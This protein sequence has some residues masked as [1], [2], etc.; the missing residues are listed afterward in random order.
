MITTRMGRDVTA[1]TI[2]DVPTVATGV[3]GGANQSEAINAAIAAVPNGTKARPS[4]I[5]L[6]YG[7]ADGREYQ[8]D[9]SIRLEG[10]TGV[11]FQGPSLNNK[12][13]VARRLRTTSV[14]T[15]TNG[16]STSGS[17]TYSAAGVT[18]V[19]GR[20]LTGTNIPDGT[21][22]DVGGD[23]SCTMTKA[24]T[25]TGTG[26]SG[27]QAASSTSLEAGVHEGYQHVNVK[28]CTDTI[29]RWIHAVG[30]KGPNPDPAT[31]VEEADGVSYA[32]AFGIGNG[33]GSISEAEHAFNVQGGSRVTVRDVKSTNVAGYNLN[34][35]SAG[36]G[37]D[38]NGVR[39]SAAYN[40]D[41][42]YPT[43]WGACFNTCFGIRVA[44]LTVFRGG[45]GGCDHE[46]LG[47]DWTIEGTEIWD[48]WISCR[49]VA[50][51]A[52]G[53]RS[54]DEVY[55]HDGHVKRAANSHGIVAC[56]DLRGG[57]R[58]WWTVENLTHEGDPMTNGFHGAFTFERVD[59]VL[60]RNCY[61][62]VAK[63]SPDMG[64][65]S[66]NKCRSAVVR[67]NLFGFA[68]SNGRGAVVYRNKID[69]AAIVGNDCNNTYDEGWKGIGTGEQVT[70]TS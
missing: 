70:T 41:A 44:G 4:V 11:I 35:T 37:S 62:V 56:R 52:Q 45:M 64:G 9:Y 5:Q 33:D 67:D 28:N 13:V 58:R 17:K 12:A 24:A 19:A 42:Q 38:N 8:Q 29:V 36:G 26:L 61:P 43:G 59:H 66:L 54:V 49:Q 10:K 69:D 55:I 30:W 51:P 50:F 57:R 20:A 34:W 48:F 3:T 1:V 46:P 68:C 39:D 47:N 22:V 27:K 2:I 16:R 32:Y 63:N 21:E 31:F 15:W 65:V 25:A 23:G 18:F 40:L 7:E 6:R 14:V 60:V 53:V